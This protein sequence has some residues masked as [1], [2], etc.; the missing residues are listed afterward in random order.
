VSIGRRGFLARLFGAGAT[1]TA[2]Q[3][4]APL[5]SLEFQK[6]EVAEV[7]RDRQYIFR[8][9]GYAPPDM[10]EA[11]GECLKARGLNVII[12]DASVEDIFE[13]NV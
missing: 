12:V 6:A 1:V 3:A 7:R 10:M 8:L 5:P 2:L 11:A 9:R 4:L 13:V